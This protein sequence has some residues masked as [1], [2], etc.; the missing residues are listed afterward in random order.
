MAER[1]VT[2]GFTQSPVQMID[3]QM[4]GQWMDDTDRQ[5]TVIHKLSL[6]TAQLYHHSK[7]AK[8]LINGCSRF[9][10]KLY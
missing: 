6:T 3:R 4:D 1:H 5:I 7:E 9:A 8:M 10:I 2:H